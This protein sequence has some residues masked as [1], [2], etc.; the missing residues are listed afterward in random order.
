MDL[1][2]LPVYLELGQVRVFAGA[3]DWPGWCRSGRDEDIALQ[4]LIAYAPRYAQA[5]ASAGQG[6]T[7]PSSPAALKVQERLPGNATTDFGAPDASPAADARPFDA[8]ELARSL[9]LLG[10]A[11][12]TFDAVVAAA[13]GRELRKG[14][15]GGGRELEAIV[16]HVIGAENAYLSS[17]GWKRRPDEG[18]HTDRLAALRS[19]VRE[20]LA[21]GSRGE[22]PERGPRGGQHWHPRYFV[23][24]SL[25]HLLDHVWE[26]ED[27][28]V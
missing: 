22:L 24:R 8:A 13:Q 12:Q 3:A 7:P 11:W 19:A 20:A 14:P 6:F 1:Q 15:R 5:I 16:E 25:W 27:R 21:A 4:N 28:V 23:R 10:A 26:I 9:A 2:V 18:N 17:L